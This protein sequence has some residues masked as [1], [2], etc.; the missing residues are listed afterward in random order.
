MEEIDSHCQFW[1]CRTVWGR[2]FGTEEYRML[3]RLRFLKS[4]LDNRLFLGIPQDSV[5]QEGSGP[6][7]LT[8]SGLYHQMSYLFAFSYCS[9]ATFFFSS[10]VWMWEL[11][12]KEGWMLKNWCFWTVVLEKTLEV[13]SLLHSKEIKPVNPK[14]NQPWIFIRGTDAEA[15]TLATWCEEPTHWKRHWLLGKIEGRRRRGRQRMI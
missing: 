1:C 7:V 10:H 3:C 2:S 13:A 5:L 15:D 14:G 8:W 11:D 12:H 9:T 6:V 4:K